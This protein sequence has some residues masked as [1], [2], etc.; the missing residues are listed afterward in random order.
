MRTIHHL[1]LTAILTSMVGCVA[2]SSFSGSQPGLIE[3][4]PSTEPLEEVDSDDWTSAPQDCEG[5]LSDSAE[6]TFQIASADD[7][8]IAAVDEDGVVV[9]VDTIDAVQHELH[10]SGDTAR[11][12]ALGNQFLLGTVLPGVNEGLQTTTPAVRALSPHEAMDGANRGDPTPQPNVNPR[13]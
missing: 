1:L 8:L 11:A 7:Q 3:I 6:L 4:D 9:C 10:E 12:E 2:P 13:G 5:R